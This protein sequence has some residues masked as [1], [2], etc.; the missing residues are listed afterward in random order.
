MRILISGGSGLIGT[1]LTKRLTKRGDEVV[2]L[3]RNANRL[4]TDDQVT[5]VEWDGKTV[6]DRVGDTDAVIN[7]AGV[8]I[9]D[10]RWTRSYKKAIL[11]SRMQT[12]LAC[13]KYIRSQKNKPKVFVAAS[14]VGYYGTKSK[15]ILDES[16]SAGKDFLADVC[17]QVEKAANKAP[18]R[19]VM[20]RTGLVLAKEG[21]AFP[22][23]LQPF[24]F[25]AG[26]YIGKGSQGFPWIH[27]DD[28]VGII[29]HAIDND[30]IDGPVNAVA[31]EVH[32]NK[33]FAKA[34]GKVLDIPV[35]GGLNERLVR[36]LLGERAIILVEGQNVVPKKAL[37]TGFDFRFVHAEEA[38]EDLLGKK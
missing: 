29:L 36:T 22:R 8:G 9:A 27:I 2:I 38:I 20:L 13:V 34:L 7:L 3:T 1:R 30:Q 14:A 5:F 19:N 4:A 21:G 37:D 26:S 31:P 11:D 33:S 18:T 12:T 28:E 10:K 17:V 6:P 24:K 16:A 25:Y 15:K 35:L 32:S 23:L